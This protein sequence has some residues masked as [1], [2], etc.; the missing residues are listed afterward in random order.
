MKKI[1][2][3]ILCL[4]M[5]IC[6]AACG[7]E[8]EPIGLPNPMTNYDSLEEINKILG[9]KLTAPGVMGVTDEAYS[10]INGEPQV[11]DYKFTINDDECDFRFSP[12]YNFDISG[13]YGKDGTVFNGTTAGELQY[14]NSEDY[15]V[16]RWANIDGQYTFALK[17]D[18]SMEQE[19][20]EGIVE[21]LIML[22]MPG[23]NA[24]EAQGVYDELAGE[25]FDT[26]SERAVAEIKACDGYVEI[27]IA[28]GNSAEDVRQWTMT[29]KLGEDGTL[30]YT[31]AK[32]V[33]AHFDADGNCTETVVAENET[34]FFTYAK[35][36]GL[37]WVGAADEQCQACVFEKME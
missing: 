6:F 35:D 28:W 5:I 36:T 19:T 8:E 23:M 9:C 29:A 30:D 16:A 31:D 22:V 3:I 10:I 7:K 13:I 20:F 2:A 26:Y 18:G 14:A 12:D 25:Y 17:N 33:D 27:E 24:S 37:A 1:I 21:E 15:K 4:S 34:G 11:A 32:V